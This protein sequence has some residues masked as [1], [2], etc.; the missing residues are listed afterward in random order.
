MF[1]FTQVICNHGYN[2]TPHWCIYLPIK[3]QHKA[4]QKFFRAQL[5]RK[6]NLSYISVWEPNRYL[7]QSNHT[8][9]ITDFSSS[10]TA[11]SAERQQE[12]DAKW[13]GLIWWLCGKSYPYCKG[14]KH[15]LLVSRWDRDV[16][17]SELWEAKRAKNTASSVFEGETVWSRRG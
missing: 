3:R 10:C 8:G 12:S 6:S 9:I 15:F 4:P 17:H 7:S 1:G 5:H 2:L 13:L 14:G 11:P 16:L